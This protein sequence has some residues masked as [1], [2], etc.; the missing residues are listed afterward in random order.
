MSIKDVL[1]CEI[2]ALEPKF[3]W[4][5]YYLRNSLKVAEETIDEVREI[6]LKEKEKS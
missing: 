2:E 4:P 1:V 3:W 5:S 6:T